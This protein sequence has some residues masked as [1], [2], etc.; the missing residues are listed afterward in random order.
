MQDDHDA[1]VCLAPSQPPSAPSSSSGAPA[2]DP[3]LVN[4]GLTWPQSVGGYGEHFSVPEPTE[5]TCNLR[6]R[7]NASVVKS[8]AQAHVSIM[9]KFGCD[10]PYKDDFDKIM[11]EVALAA[12]HGPENLHKCVG[13]IDTSHGS[14]DSRLLDLVG[15]EPKG[16]L[17]AIGCKTFGSLWSKAFEDEITN[18]KTNGT[19]ELVP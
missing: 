9:N 4:D 18:L 5:G 2:T 6:D 13:D 14:K 3:V 17:R 19:Y 12:K 10:D 15:K 11:C 16:Y 1:S 7:G 8:R